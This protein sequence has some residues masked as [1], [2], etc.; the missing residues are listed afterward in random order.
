MNATE[1]NSTAPDS[2][3]K[4]TP[5]LQILEAFASEVVTRAVRRFV[6]QQAD[7]VA[8][9]TASEFEEISRVLHDFP[10]ARHSRGRARTIALKDLRKAEEDVQKSFPALTKAADELAAFLTVP[11]QM[12]T[13]IQSAHHAIKVINEQ[14]KN[15]KSVQDTTEHKD[16]DITSLK[17]EVARLRDELNQRPQPSDT[18]E[19]RIEEL[20]KDLVELR[21]DQAEEKSLLAIDLDEKVQSLH[22]TISQK[23]DA[24]KFEDLRRA[25]VD[26][27]HKGLQQIKD[28]ALEEVRVGLQKLR[29][30]ANEEA[31]QKQS[32]HGRYQAPSLSNGRANGTETVFAEPGVSNVKHHVDGLHTIT[33]QLKLRMDNLT[34]DEVVKAMVDQL[35]TQYPH[36]KQASENYRQVGIHV[37]RVEQR[38]EELAQQLEAEKTNTA[39]ALDQALIAQNAAQLAENKIQKLERMALPFEKVSTPETPAVPVR[40]PDQASTL[41]LAATQAEKALKIAQ[42]VETKQ[43]KEMEYWKKA[44]MTLNG[45]IKGEQSVMQDEIADLKSTVRIL[46]EKIK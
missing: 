21:D 11:S 36:A 39:K 23:P 20:R 15:F 1:P 8:Q 9:R 40:T 42:D 31:S 32:S 4:S 26:G 33:Q 25:L 27:L 3:A 24:Q 46:Q 29:N 38:A 7:M 35:S 12:E 28:K 14:L 37:A 19:R 6:A 43:L 16:E 44:T 5:L 30:E 34:T 22:D 41:K 10:S 45:E 2:V 18:I 13:E 17:L